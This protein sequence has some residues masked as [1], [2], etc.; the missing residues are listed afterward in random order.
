MATIS[1]LFICLGNICRSTM[2]EAVFQRKVADAGLQNQIAI[3]SAATSRWEIGQPPHPGTRRI[4][5]EKNIAYDHRARQIT[6][7]DMDTHDYLITM[8]EENWND[9]HA[10]G[11]ARGSVV[12]LMEYA[13]EAREREI[14]DPYY[15]GDFEG[16]Y[17][18]IDAATDGLLQALRRDHVL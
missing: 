7:K 10:L 2:A 4:L 15:S 11:P 13:P 8:D 1:V 17:G 16:V 3:D 18:Q 12:R 5:R 6:Q 14:A 9:V